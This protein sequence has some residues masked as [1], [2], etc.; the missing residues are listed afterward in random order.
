VELQFPTR[1]P[2]DEDNR[3]ILTFDILPV[4]WLTEN[5]KEIETNS[6]DY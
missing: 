1:L 3:N 5:R 2:S 4:T 6:S